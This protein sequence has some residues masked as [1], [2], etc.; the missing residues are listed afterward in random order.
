MGESF[1]RLFTESDHSAET[2]QIELLIEESDKVQH[3][4]VV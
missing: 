3:S 1:I 4:L 2:Q